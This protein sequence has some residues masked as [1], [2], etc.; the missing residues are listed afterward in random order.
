MSYV[1]GM[2]W[3]G[4]THLIG[5]ADRVVAGKHQEDNDAVTTRRCGNVRQAGAPS[6]FVTDNEV[7]VLTPASASE[8]QPN[9]YVPGEEGASNCTL[10]PV[11][12]DGG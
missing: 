9:Q 5:F 7:Q 2:S 1:A 4:W 6:Q 11:A 10:P 12:P 3:A 8:T